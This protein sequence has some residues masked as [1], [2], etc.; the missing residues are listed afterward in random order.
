MIG[1]PTSWK[2]EH[3]VTVSAYREPPNPPEGQKLLEQESRAKGESEKGWREKTLAPWDNQ[4]QRAGDHKLSRWLSFGEQSA[5]T[6]PPSL[7]LLF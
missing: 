6:K 2:T 5:G 3:E 4:G 7:K 1:S